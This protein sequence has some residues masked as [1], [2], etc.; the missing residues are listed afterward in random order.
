METFIITEIIEVSSQ[1][2]KDLTQDYTTSE[3]HFTF[4]CQ[5][6]VFKITYTDDIENYK[7]CQSLINEPSVSKFRLNVQHIIEEFD[8]AAIQ[9]YGTPP[10]LYEISYEYYIIWVKKS[11]KSFRI[12]KK[13]DPTNFDKCV[14]FLKRICG[15]ERSVAV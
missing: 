12:Y 7:K 2:I 11:Y 4:T 13:D 15:K 9:K 3:P 1:E 10:E 6:Q 5:G 8:I 14:A